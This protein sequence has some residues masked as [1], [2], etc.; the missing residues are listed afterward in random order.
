MN[1]TRDHNM[2]ATTGGVEDLAPADPREH[3]EPTEAERPLS[4]WFVTFLCVCFGW[5]GYYLQRYSADYGALSYDENAGLG[6]AKTNVVKQVDPYVLGRRLFESVCA[7]CHQPDGQGV[8]GQ[9]PPL[10][11]SEWVL[12]PGPARLIRI[13]LDGLQGP[14]TVKGVAYNNNMTPH[15]D[16]LTDAQ[17]AA[18]LTYL[19]TQKDWGHS[20]APVTPE[21]VAAIRSKTK[22]RA[23]LG[24]WTAA[25]LLALPEHEPAP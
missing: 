2:A 17:I 4:L 5:G 25:E 1:Q 8:A 15:R 12:A 10:V 3:I 9:Y 6:G 13:V 16:A 24:A 22:D 21:E 7:R 23:A 18:V 20:A 19:R 14:I 11:G